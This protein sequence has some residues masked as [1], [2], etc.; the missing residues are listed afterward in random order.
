MNIITSNGSKKVAIPY[1]QKIAIVSENATAVI[2]YSTEPNSPVLFYEFL[3][4]TDSV[5]ELGTFDNDREIIIEC[6]GSG[7]VKYEVA[8]SPVIV[9]RLDNQI[10]IGVIPPGT[11]GGI[12]ISGNFEVGGNFVVQGDIDVEGIITLKNE[13]LH[14][15]DT[16]ESHDLIIASGSDLSDDRVLSLVTGDSDRTITLEGDPTLDDWFDQS[17]KTDSTPSFPGVTIDLQPSLSSDAVRKDYVDSLIQNGKRKE[18]CLVATTE[19]IT[20]SGEQTIDGVLTAESRVLVWKQTDATENGIY[21]SSAG[22]W[23]RSNDANTGQEILGSLVMGLQ[24]TL[25]EGYQFNN[26][27]TSAPTIGGTNITFVNLGSTVLH[28]STIGLQGGTTD[29]YYHLTSSEHANT[30]VAAGF[31]NGED[32]LALPTGD[33]YGGEKV[34][35]ID[36]SGLSLFNTSDEGEIIQDDGSI[37]Q[38]YGTYT[39]TRKLYDEATLSAGTDWFRFA[40]WNSAQGVQG[41]FYISGICGGAYFSY[42]VEINSAGSYPV[43]SITGKNNNTSLCPANIRVANDNVVTNRYLEIQAHASQAVTLSRCYTE[44]IGLT[45]LEFTNGNADTLVFNFPTN[46]A[47]SIYYN[48]ALTTVATDFMALGV[49]AEA[50]RFTGAQNILLGGLL[51]AGTGAAKVLAIPNGT[52]GA[53]L[54]DAVQVT[55][56]DLTAG[57]TMLD[58]RTEGSGSK[59]VGVPATNAGS[60]ALNYNGST[61]Y[62]PYAATPPP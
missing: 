25:Y 41:K 20:L 26:S 2:K 60:I 30:L 31:V 62:I 49:L 13:G 58:I 14:I 10:G 61:I 22:A 4:L 45:P 33:Y 47:N 6:L 15:L 44:F 9:A 37:Q 56:A 53:A 1:G 7:T 40:T 27:N 5:T 12:A 52:Q 28:N 55:S 3:R 54:A 34:K 8:E 24:G 29:E 46:T 32:G 42:T 39:R 43:I 11:P 38:K 48:F 23:A 19:D 50:I 18:N 35:A 57:N 16:D 17:V 36:N 21:V 59:L 51:S